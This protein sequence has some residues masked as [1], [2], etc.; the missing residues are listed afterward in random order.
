M[1][2]LAACQIVT[3]LKKNP[4]D[5]RKSGREAGEGVRY[6]DR[7][8]VGAG[9]CITERVSPGRRCATTSLPCYGSC[10]NEVYDAD[11]RDDLFPGVARH[12]GYC[13]RELR[14][15]RVDRGRH[16]DD[17]NVKEQT[18]LRRQEVKEGEMQTG[19]RQCQCSCQ[20]FD[21]E[22]VLSCAITPLS[23][24]A[25]ETLVRGIDVAQ[26]VPTCM[27]LDIPSAQNDTWEIPR[28][29]LMHLP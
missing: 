27:Y 29:L 24:K 7:E 17:S 23:S 8:A 3:T 25:T 1:T 14:G 18:A 13:R 6:G 10:E 5:D 22:R 20:W 16:T 9:R 4:R 15:M 26:Q 12:L 28:V 21:Q 2:L 19:R 11:E